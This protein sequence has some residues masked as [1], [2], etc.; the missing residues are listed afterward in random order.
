MALES[1][2]KCI[3]PLVYIKNDLISVT[4][5]AVEHNNA[6]KRSCNFVTRALVLG[7]QVQQKCMPLRTGSMKQWKVAMGSGTGSGSSCQEF[8]CFQFPV[9]C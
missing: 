2:A 7:Q 8:G 6:G 5:A 9:W 3:I 1:A 4:L